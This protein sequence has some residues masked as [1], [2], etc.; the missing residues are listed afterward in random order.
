MSN[1]P[2][3]RPKPGQKVNCRKGSAIDEWWCSSRPQSNQLQ[4]MP[5]SLLSEPTELGNHLHALET[6]I[7]HPFS[8]DD[9]PRS[10]LPLLFYFTRIPWTLHSQTHQRVKRER[11]IHPVLQMRPCVSQVFARMGLPV[12]GVTTDNTA[13]TQTDLPL[14]TY[15]L[16]MYSSCNKQL[17]L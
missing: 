17:I 6:R 2:V 12:P 11:W 14:D 13:C 4:C 15:L 10:S 3:C 7:H 5:A 9:G 16:E 8:I 1:Y